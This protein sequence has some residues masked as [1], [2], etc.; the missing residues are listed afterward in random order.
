MRRGDEPQFTL[1]RL[2]PAPPVVLEP[3]PSAQT[4]DGDGSAQSLVSRRSRRNGSANGVDAGAD[5]RREIVKI[6]CER[7]HDR[8]TETSSTIGVEIGRCPTGS[9][10]L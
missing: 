8:G 2:C 5:Q 1:D 7:R 10:T 3:E 9:R 4:S 6:V